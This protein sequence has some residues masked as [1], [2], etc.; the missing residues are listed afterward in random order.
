[1]NITLEYINSELPAITIFQKLGYDYYD[2]KQKEERENISE[3]ILKDRLIQT[4]KRINTTDEWEISDNNVQK[5]YNELTNVY[6]SSLM[7]SNQKVWE[8]IRGASF[9][10]KQVINGREEYKSVWYID[11]LH[12]ENNDFLV[13]N[14]MKFHGRPQNSVPDLTVFINGIPIAVIECKSPISPS[15]FDKAYEDLRY[16]QR[17]SE[18]LF[19]YNQICAA[20]FEVGG[21]YGAIGAGKPHYSYYRTKDITDLEALIE[22]PPT[23]QDILIYNL[24]K[25]ENLLDLIRHFV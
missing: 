6:S 19:W 10:V 23:A 1:M 11:Y 21:R 13:V 3:V 4:I 22:R 24:F 15:A 8:L 9:S 7:E 12:P 17:N 2:G 18:K 20:I 5:A 25:K 16:Y 14:Q